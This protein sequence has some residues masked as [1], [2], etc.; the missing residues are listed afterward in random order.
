MNPAERAEC[1]EIKKMSDKVKEL[2]VRLEQLKKKKTSNQT[3]ISNVEKNIEKQEIIFKQS[4]ITAITTN[5]TNML[6]YDEIYMKGL[7]GV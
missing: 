1:E 6:V 4:Q 2:D 7:I 3:L 5:L